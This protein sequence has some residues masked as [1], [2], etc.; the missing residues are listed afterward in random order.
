MEA[1]IQLFYYTNFHIS[2]ILV[3][4]YIVSEMSCFLF[5]LGCGLAHGYLHRIPLNRQFPKSLNQAQLGEAAAA[6]GGVGLAGDPQATCGEYQNV[7]LNE[8]PVSSI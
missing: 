2:I 8:S 1:I 6:S 3:I 4:I 7:P 5:R